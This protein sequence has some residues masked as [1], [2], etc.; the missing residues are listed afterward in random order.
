MCY[1][2]GGVT[3][4]M[5]KSSF[6]QADILPSWIVKNAKGKIRQLLPCISVSLMYLFHFQKA[7]KVT[8]KE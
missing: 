6:T 8:K 4:T 5:T 7:G 3:R 2:E 1:E